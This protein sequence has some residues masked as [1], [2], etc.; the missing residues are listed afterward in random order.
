MAE[1]DLQ[2]QQSLSELRAAQEKAIQA[3]ERKQA[4]TLQELQQKHEKEAKLL[5]ERL[6][7]AEKRAKSSMNDEVEKLLREFEQSQHNHQVQIADLQKSHQEQM[8]AMRQGQQDEL[9]RA[10]QVVQLRKTGGP[11]TSTLRCWPPVPDQ[12]VEITPRDPSLVQ[13]YIS[14]VSA[15]PTIKRHQEAIQTALTTK[16]IKY[17]IVDVA[18]SEPAL[19]HMRKGPSSNKKLPQIFVGGE[20]RGQLEDLEAAIEKDQLQDFLKPRSNNVRKASQPS[21]H[22]EPVTPTLSSGISTASFSTPPTTPRIPPPTYRKSTR[23]EDDALFKEM[24][25]ELGHTDFSKIDLNI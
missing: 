13:L 25:K 9:R 23:D 18:K 10:A 24:E 17:Q 14:S 7:S 15:N 19:Q 8:S 3:L 12:Q 16:Q 5:R 22:N 4:Q 11:G 1:K 2:H 21:L 20:Y 6:E